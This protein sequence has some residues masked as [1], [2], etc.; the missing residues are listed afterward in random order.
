MQKRLVWVTAIGCAVMLVQG[1]NRRGSPTSPTTV[2]P[3][4]SSQSAAVQA[5]QIGGD[6]LTG[7]LA[8]GR[9]LQ[10]KAFA[11]LADGTE[12]DVTSF[13]TWSSQNPDVAEVT[14]SGLVTARRRGAGLIRADYQSTT[15]ETSFSVV[16]GAGTTS[17]TPPGSTPGGPSGPG[18]PQ[19]PPSNPSPTPMPG[20]PSPTPTVKSLTITGDNNVPVGRSA[21]L[22][23]IAHMSDGSQRDVTADAD[24]RSDNSLIG[25][26][27]QSGI[28]T[29]IAPG[30]NVVTAEHNGQSA[31]KPV[32]V[33]PC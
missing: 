26:I 24:W 8:V 11:R 15:G 32:T 2:T 18:S 1:C 10:L 28:L 29:G 30:S 22:R 14:A 9:T 17:D 5:I 6:S 33:T 31:S 19:P 4:S 23:A 12:R 7:S 27:S 16:D 13:A 25:A 3:P 20:N 21:Q